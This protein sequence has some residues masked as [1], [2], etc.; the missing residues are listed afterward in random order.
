MTTNIAQKLG[1]REK[2]ITVPCS[3]FTD[4]TRNV[5]IEIEVENV[6]IAD[7]NADLGQVWSVGRDGSLRP[8]EYSAE[9]KSPRSGYAGTALLESIIAADESIPLRSGSFSWRCATHVHVDVRDKQLDDL[10]YSLVLYALIEP[11]IFAWDGT[12][13][14][15]SRFCMPWWVCAED[16]STASAIAREND[17]HDLHN[18]ISRFSKYTAMNLAPMNKFGTIEFRHAQGTC[19]KDTLI[20]YINIC[21]DIINVH[22]RATSTPCIELVLEFMESEPETFI[23]KWLSEGSANALLQPTIGEIP[24]TTEIMERAASTALALAEL[25]EHIAVTTPSVLNKSILLELF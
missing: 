9:I 15:E 4:P 3:V 1:L 13:R 16:I 22:E 6:D 21:L 5:G 10:K 12:G 7:I 14:H 2:E 11:F 19:D 23:R 20:E 24:L 17:D 18:W 25:D 8:P